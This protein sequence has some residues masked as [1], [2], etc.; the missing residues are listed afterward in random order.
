MFFPCDFLKEVILYKLNEQLLQQGHQQVALWEYMRWLGIWMLLA[1]TDGHQ[2]DDFWKTLTSQEDCRF[3]GAP[4]RL[5]DLLS[6]R[7]FNQILMYHQTYEDNPPDYK[8][9]FYPICKFIKA[10][11]KNMKENFVPSW[12]T[13]LD[14]S[15]SLWTNMFTCPGFVFCPRKPWET[16]NEYHTIACAKSNII[17][18]GEIVEGK[19]CPPELPEQEYNNCGGKTVGLLLQM[20][21]PIWNSGRV[22]ILDSG[23][24][25]LQGLIE[26][27]K[28]GLYASALI[29]KEG[30][31]QNM[32][33][34]RKS[35][36][37]FRIKRL[38]V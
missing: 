23:F 19:D 16:G 28:M 24:C 30:T 27:A 13:C 33:R 32:W 26:L 37:S 5:N 35:N 11:N 36:S 14:E 6:K 8:D 10:W 18:F 38:E 3:E 31:G 29:K 17:F 20:T 2:R 25:V 4:F 7:R 12:V 9:S 15:M 21:Q 22:V 1:T 34:A